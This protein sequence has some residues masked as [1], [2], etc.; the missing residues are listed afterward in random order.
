MGILV[1]GIQSPAQ[2]YIDPAS[3]SIL[4]QIALSGFA[5]IGALLSLFGHRLK[6]AVASI[7][8]GKKYRV[9]DVT[10]DDKKHD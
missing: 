2:A 9:D 10:A 3:G 7:W 4:A 8:R 6:S 1:A 5:G